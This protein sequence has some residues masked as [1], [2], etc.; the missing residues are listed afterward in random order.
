M[1]KTK[2]V[3]R[4]F[5]TI[6]FTLNY[7]FFYLNVHVSKT[8]TT[9]TGTLFNFPMVTR[10]NLSLCT[11]SLSLTHAYPHTYTKS[12]FWNSSFNGFPIFNFGNDFV[13]ISYNIFVNC[14]RLPAV[15]GV[16]M[17]KK[18]AQR[19]SA[20]SSGCNVLMVFINNK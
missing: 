6:G 9:T 2:L 13:T 19:V 10:R 1:N 11:N 12:A 17:K 7:Y 3:W 15:P 5:S 18:E 16:R 8:T 14:R 20:H 4:E